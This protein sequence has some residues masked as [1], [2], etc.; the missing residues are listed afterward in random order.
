MTVPAAPASHA[1]PGVVAVYVADAGEHACEHER[2]T[3]LGF[4]RRLAALLGYE[5]GGAYD[6]ARAYGGHV[7]FVPSNTLTG[8]QA[9]ALGIRG[10]R[11]LFGGVVPQRFVRTKAISH[12]LVAPGAATVDGWNPDFARHAGDAVL[13]GFSAFTPEDALEAGLRLLRQGPARIKPVRASGG[14]GQSVARDAEELRAL[15]AAIAPEEIRTHGV[16]LE[17]DLEEMRTFSVGQVRVAD[18]VASYFGVQ[19][20]TSSNQGEEVYGGSDLTVVRGGFD[21]LLRLQADAGILHAVHQARRYDAAVDACF[22]G[23]FASRRN[24]DV[25]VGRDATGAERSGVLEQSWRVGGATGC[26][27]AALEIFRNDPAR[28][29]VR[30]LGFE[31]FGDSP[32]PPPGACVHFR[33]DDPQVGRLTKYTI[34]EP[35]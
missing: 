26:E 35:E 16:V 18:L 7:Y 32:E 34:V 31:V 1:A 22:P 14:R 15:L 8:E 29:L 4:A 20:L 25:L 33:G 10:P 6:A 30:A 24:Y 19:K 17:E 27:L 13:A 3:Q 11:D 5:A 28:Q 12:G 23:F 21:A 9:A 2:V